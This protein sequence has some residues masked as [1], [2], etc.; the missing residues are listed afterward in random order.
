MKQFALANIPG[1]QSTTEWR[2]GKNMKEEIVLLYITLPPVE[3]FSSQPKRTKILIW[4]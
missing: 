1:S 2:Q 4:D 3:E